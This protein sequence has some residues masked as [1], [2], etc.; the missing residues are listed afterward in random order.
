MKTF[1]SV[2]L[3]TVLAA[4]AFGCSSG[5][6]NIEEAS[7]EIRAA[8]STIESWSSDIE[9]DMKIQG[10]S[11]KMTGYARG[12]GDSV[13]LE[14]NTN[15]MGQPMNLR[16][17]IED[18]GTQW[19]ELDVAG[20]TVVMKVDPSQMRDL[21]GQLSGLAMPGSSTLGQSQ[22]P[23][24]ALDSMSDS[25]DLEY[26]GVATMED[27]TEVYVISGVLKDSVISAQTDPQMR[28]QLVDLA[29]KTRVLFGVGDGFV[30]RIESWAKDAADDAK[31]GMTQH[32]RNVVLNA[33]LD[34]SLFVY[35]PPPDVEV[36]DMA[37]MLG[38]GSSALMQQ[39]ANP[40]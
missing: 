40:N 29:G 34:D 3:V 12:K 2:A 5:P 37:E 4:F 38:G 15:V 16:S 21:G 32:Y 33:A 7:A 10:M 14:M 18:G 26:V 35:T 25:Y 17:V 13:A 36:M 20:Q 27:G 28:K 9:L 39:F 6:R 23:R 8:A 11:M 24:K 1:S 22:D 19:T 30:R 31:P